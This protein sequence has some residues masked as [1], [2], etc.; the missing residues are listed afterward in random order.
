MAGLGG[1]TFIDAR[2]S[3]G[4]L[5]RLTEL[6]DW[7]ACL[8]TQAHRSGV[9]GLGRGGIGRTGTKKHDARRG[10]MV[11]ASMRALVRRDLVNRDMCHRTVSGS[12]ICRRQGS[13]WER[14]Q[15]PTRPRL[16]MLSSLALACV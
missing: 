12:N 2:R 10:D 3:S 1:G 16:A 15:V 8:V 6:T 5:V 14:R 9:L 13:A 4:D 7:L 11:W